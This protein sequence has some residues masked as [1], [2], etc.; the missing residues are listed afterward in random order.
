LSVRTFPDK[1]KAMAYFK[2]YNAKPEVFKNVKGN[3][4]Q[5]FVISPA[6]YQILMKQKSADSYAQFFKVYFPQ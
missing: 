3:T 2:A 6:N 1:A 4:R 5:V